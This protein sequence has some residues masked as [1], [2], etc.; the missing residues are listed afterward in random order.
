MISTERRW[1]FRFEDV[2]GR[3]ETARRPGLRRRLLALTGR[4]DLD[5]I[6]KPID[7][8]RQL[9]REASMIKSP[10]GRPPFRADHVGSL[11]RPPILRQ[12]FKDFFAKRI[13]D[14]HFAQIQDQ[15]IRNVVKLQEDVGLRVVTDG[16]FRRGSYWSRFVERTGGLDIRESLFK[17]RD[18]HGHEV[19]FTA[20]Y[21][22]G[23]VRRR[24]PIALDEL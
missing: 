6:Y 20:P 10:N 4:A 9:T 2:A 22:I 23:K 24:Q 3:A 18:E 5:F 11:L 8:A 14:A 12:A 17:F 21:V 15:C 16:E 19:D 7:K 1:V 13:D